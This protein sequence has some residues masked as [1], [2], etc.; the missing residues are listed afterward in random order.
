MVL[1]NKV[2]KP[3]HPIVEYGRN[4]TYSTAGSNF[5]SYQYLLFSNESSIW[6]DPYPGEY[7]FSLRFLPYF[8]IPIIFL[9]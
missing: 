4:Y 3:D 6:W 7:F 2:V 9:S 1:M 5:S 8:A